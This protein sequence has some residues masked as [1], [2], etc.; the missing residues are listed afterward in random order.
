MKKI[1]LTALI[2]AAVSSF[3]AETRSDY[4][5]SVD[6]TRLKA[7]T[8]MDQSRRLPGD[9]LA[10]N[11]LA[12]K[13]LHAA[14]ENNLQAQGM[15]KDAAQADFVVAYSVTVTKKPRISATGYGPFRFSGGQVWVD[16]EIE[17][18]AMVDFLDAQTGELIWRGY[19]R[20]T[21]G[22]PEKSEKQINDAIKKLIDKFAKDRKQQAE[23]REA[24]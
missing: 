14:I 9:P 23:K 18:D 8:F 16:E 21:I 3:A 7:F 6:L 20:A 15:Q 13:R 4:D 10:S 19:I 1:F 22:K 24:R 12:D 11:R 17:G 5:R 2:L